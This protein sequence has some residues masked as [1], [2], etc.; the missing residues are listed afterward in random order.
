MDSYVILSNQN[1]LQIKMIL[2]AYEIPRNCIGTVC[3]CC[4][5]W[6]TLKILHALPKRHSMRIFPS[7]I[8][9][10]CMANQFELA[11]EFNHT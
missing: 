4:S 8:D 3:D 1:V 9:V 11:I 10:I 2:N 7:I 6:N 5:V